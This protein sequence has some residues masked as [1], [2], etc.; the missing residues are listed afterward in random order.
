MGDVGC[1]SFQQYKVITS[2]EGGLVVTDDEAMY[3]R[4]RMQHDCAARFWED[5]Q[6][7]KAA[8]TM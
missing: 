4:A 8:M 2:G 1:F 5:R 3:D 7:P 6:A